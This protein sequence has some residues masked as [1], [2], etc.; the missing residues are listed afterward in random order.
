MGNL[1]LLLV[2]C[3]TLG[4]VQFATV[5]MA[6]ACFQAKKLSIGF[7]GFI[8]WLGLAIIVSVVVIDQFIVLPWLIETNFHVCGK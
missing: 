7:L 2:G 6:Y 5:L 4:W 3:L 8:L 1:L